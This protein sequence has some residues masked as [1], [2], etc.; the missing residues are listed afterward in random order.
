MYRFASVAASAVLVV[1]GEIAIAV[2][3]SSVADQKSY[4]YL[5][6]VAAFILAVAITAITDYRRDEKSKSTRTDRTNSST[7]ASEKTHVLRGSRRQKRRGI[8]V[9]TGALLVFGA[10]IA[11]FWGLAYTIGT[12]RVQQDLAVG[13]PLMTCSIIGLTL[14]I[15]LCRGVRISLTFSSEG[16]T[17]TDAS[18]RRLIRWDQ[19]TNFHTMKPLFF[20]WYLVA[21]S[22][23]GSDYFLGPWGFDDTNDLI[24]I[25]DLTASGISRSDVDGALRYWRKYN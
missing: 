18:G 4:S 21:E 2:S 23:P 6:P 14:G 24:R 20:T 1:I 11:F 5:I 19:A 8:I 7:P 25:C 12:S 13:I 17:L 15:A 3:A 16:I 22:V 10:Y 9:T